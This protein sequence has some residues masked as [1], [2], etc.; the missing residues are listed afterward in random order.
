MSCPECPY[1]AACYNPGKN[2]PDCPCG[3]SGF[4]EYVGLAFHCNREPN[5]RHYPAMGYR[6]ECSCGTYLRFMKPS[7][8]EAGLD[9]NRNFGA[10]SGETEKGMRGRYSIARG[11]NKKEESEAIF[12]EKSK[13]KRVPKPERVSRYSLALGKKD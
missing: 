13:K 3:N 10:L 8:F 5:M 9:W 1:Y 11:D 2:S 4:N 7:S 6:V 12:E